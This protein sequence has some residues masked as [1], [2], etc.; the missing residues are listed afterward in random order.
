VEE[1]A[2]NVWEWTSSLYESYPYIQSDGREDP[3]S[4]GIRMQRG[5]SWDNDAE[6]ARAACRISGFWDDFNIVRGFR[7]AFGAGA[8]S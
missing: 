6:D 8:G 4:T 2:G 7:L 5:G 1:M 3:K